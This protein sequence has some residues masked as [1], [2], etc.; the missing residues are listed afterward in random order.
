[1]LLLDEPTSHLDTYTQ[2]ALEKAMKNYK[3]AILM[4]SHDYYS[5]ANCLDYVLIIEDKTLRKMSMKKFRR[6]IY[7][8]HFDRDYLELEKKEKN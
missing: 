1:M 7:A 3:G 2:I 8:N 6:K 4:I 5:I